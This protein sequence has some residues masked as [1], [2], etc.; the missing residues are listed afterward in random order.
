MSANY[1]RPAARASVD[2]IRR[3]STENG[4]GAPVWAVQAA[5]QKLDVT[6]R[7]VWNWLKCG[8]PELACGALDKDLETQVLQ[9]L[10]TAHGNRKA[11][12][13][14]MTA[15]GLYSKGYV[16]FTRDLAKLTPIQLAG[17]TEG[18]KAALAKGLYLKG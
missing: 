18:V 2:H 4:G 9:A 16:Q 5:A 10:A 11:A 8:V 13:A 14:T 6:E 7:T 12:W 17:V 1:D 3:V 15:S